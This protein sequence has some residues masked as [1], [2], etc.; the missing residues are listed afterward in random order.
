MIKPLFDD[1]N[2][3]QSRDN[4]LSE[5]ERKSDVDEAEAEDNQMEE[6]YHWEEKTDFFYGLWTPTWLIQFNKQSGPRNL[7]REGDLTPFEAL[8]L[9]LSEDLIDLNV[10]STNKY[11]RIVIGSF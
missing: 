1:I 2:D 8:S 5:E 3:A 9:L 7:P 6:E 11:A 10:Q 4:N